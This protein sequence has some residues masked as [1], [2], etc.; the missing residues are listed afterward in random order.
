MTAPSASCELWVDGQRFAD[1]GSD[2]GQGEATALSDL[3]IAWGRDGQNEQP[4]P[5]SCSFGILDPLGGD[6][7]MDILHVGS[8]IDI[9][10]E[11]QIATEGAPTWGPTTYDDG[12]LSTKADG[13]V[14]AL[15][16]SLNHSTARY[17]AQTLKIIYDQP[18]NSAYG[19]G[20]TVPPRSFSPI[21][22]LP[23]AWDTIPRARQGETW[24]FNLRGRAPIGV[25]WG[26][27][28]TAYSSPYPGSKPISYQMQFLPG[29]SG[30][31]IGTGDWQPWAGDAYIKTLSEPSWLAI[32]TFTTTDPFGHARWNNQPA[33]LAWAAAAS[34]WDDW[35][36]YGTD[37]YID[38]LAAYPPGSTIRRVLAFSG[39]V[40]DLTIS[41]TGDPDQ[42][43]RISATAMDLGA[44]LGN[45]IIG[46]DPWPAQPLST[47]ADRICQLA[48]ISASPRIRIDP[49]LG[50]LAV[51]YRDV[52]A[53]PAYGLLQ[54]LAQTGAGV[55]WAATHAITGPFLWIENP[56]RRAA[57]REF[58]LSGGQ[59]KIIGATSGVA[60]LSACDLLEDPATWRQDTADVIT[61][62]AVGWLEQSLDDDGQPQTTE[63]TETVS[64][65]AAIAI[66]GTR[67]L[68]ISTEL[69]N[70]L[71]ASEMASRILSH[72]RDVGWRLDG[73]SLDTA[74]AL[75]EI[76]S[77]DGTARA[78]TLLNLLDGT[79]R[80]GLAIVLVDMPSYAPRGAVSSA[81]LEGGS[82]E[83]RDGFWALALTVTPAAGQG[84][85]AA[86]AEL[87]P[88][89]AWQQWDPTIQWLDT[90]GVA[91]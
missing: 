7:P 70:A 28:I 40:S 66:Y 42:R 32:G 76:G 4:G 61:T 29:W 85:S 87:D 68:S 36:L 2:L 17:E 83:F 6:D 53:Q 23:S 10:A 74:L 77:I 73:L 41:P 88:A 35:A 37:L 71:D 59:I 15:D 49:P 22:E 30:T 20:L 75:D 81:Y 86:W 91:P 62:V 55:L 13:P 80:M 1:A 43:V 50:D 69:I 51:S 27:R 18:F 25:S 89:W 48:G 26:V 11:G 21:G 33:D 60:L 31:Q 19:P 84:S 72:A 38:D 52:D 34:S 5:A 8:K 44:D 39:S 64:D 58:D 24:R 82:Y 56:A 16:V 78:E 54:D 57:V 63:R 67:R 79:I 47:R 46:D 12:S 65:P 3:K 9:W 45:R 90:F 14:P